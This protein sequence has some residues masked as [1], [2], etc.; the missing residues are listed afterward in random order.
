MRSEEWWRR[1]LELLLYPYLI[2]DMTPFYIARRRRKINRVMFPMKHIFMGIIYKGV[3]GRYMNC[4]PLPPLLTP[5]SS[6]LTDF[7]FP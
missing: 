1:A 3:L 7:C 2:H 4:A 5:N 6:L